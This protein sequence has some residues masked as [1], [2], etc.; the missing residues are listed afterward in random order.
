MLEH[1]VRFREVHAIVQV[2][3][4][5]RV[6]YVRFYKERDDLLVRLLRVQRDY[7]AER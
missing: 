7:V 6:Y 2:G 1:Y 5:T 3:Y 4:V